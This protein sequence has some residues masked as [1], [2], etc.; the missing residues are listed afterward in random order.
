MDI[1]TKSQLFT[2]YNKARKA[3]HQGKIDGARLN[4]TLGILLSKSYPHQYNTTIRTCDCPDFHRTGK[5]CKHIIAGW[6]KVR[7]SQTAPVAA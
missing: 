1:A 7:M 4:R 6:I 5:P 2:T 3:A